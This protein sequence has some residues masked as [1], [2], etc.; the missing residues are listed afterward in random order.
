MPEELEVDHLVIH[1]WEQQRSSSQFPC[2]YW[3]CSHKIHPGDAY[4][5]ELYPEGHSLGF[6]LECSAFFMAQALNTLM[7]NQLGG[8]R[9]ND[10]RQTRL[11]S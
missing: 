1:H 10:D 5:V 4:Y 9:G 3:D 6:C 8:R 11:L 2:D 7:D